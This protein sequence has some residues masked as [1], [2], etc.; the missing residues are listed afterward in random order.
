MH[1]V[2]CMVVIVKRVI[3]HLKYQ[4]VVLSLSVAPSRVFFEV[5]GSCH[6]S[7]HIDVH[8]TSENRSSSRNTRVV[9]TYY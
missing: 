2:Y 8:K 9:L 5:R 3:P 6:M 7:A 1:F 4:E